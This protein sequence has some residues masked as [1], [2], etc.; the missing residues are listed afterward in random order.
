MAKKTRRPSA[1]LTA[2]ARVHDP[3]QN[4]RI[5]N[6]CLQQ[7]A[8]HNRTVQ[9]LL[10]HQ[11]DEP[12]QK[13]TAKGVTGLFGRWPAWRTE[14]EGL[15]HI[16]SLVA[17]GAISAAQD[18]VAKWEDTNLEHAV[19]VAQALRDG[20]PIPK[21]VQRRTLDARQLFRSRKREERTTSPTTSTSAPAS[22]WNARR[23]PD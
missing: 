8:V 2:T 5:V 14:N 6:A 15:S 13:N 22:S 17:R 18:Q 10:R 12:L 20:K 9:H 3:E 19:L 11:S 7:R 23:S 16:P 1:F 4:A 21:R